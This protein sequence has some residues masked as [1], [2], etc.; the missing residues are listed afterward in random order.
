[1]FLINHFDGLK[2]S[3]KVATAYLKK[4]QPFAK[5]KEKDIWIFGCTRH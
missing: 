4:S 3:Y 1:M 5:K 2:L